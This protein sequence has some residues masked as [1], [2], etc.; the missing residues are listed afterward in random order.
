MVDPPGVGL[1]EHIERV[2]EQ[3]DLRYQQRFD[4][5]EAAL[6]AAL[7]AQEKAVQTAMTASEKASDKANEAAE[8][9]FEGLNELRGIVNDIGSL[10][11][12]R[13]EAES[14]LGALDEKVN[15]S[16]GRSSGLNAGFGYLIGAVGLIG[17]VV[18]LL[19]R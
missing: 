15:E 17:G 13:A 2:L 16:R 8:K 9:R 3:M 12:P 11:M 19:L 10:Q 1:K 5:Q 18:G 14:R 7:L 6:R 4:A